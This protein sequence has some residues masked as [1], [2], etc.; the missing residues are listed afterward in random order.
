MKSRGMEWVGHEARGRKVYRLWVGKT[1][2][3][4]PLGRSK[5]RWE[6][7]MSRDLRD[8]VCGG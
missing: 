2:G 5:L 1:E 8:I 7:K 3:K 6:D 4:R